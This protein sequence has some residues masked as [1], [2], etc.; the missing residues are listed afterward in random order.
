[1]K[2]PCGH[3]FHIKCLSDWIMVKLQCPVDRSQLPGF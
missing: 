3:M 2:T 1:M